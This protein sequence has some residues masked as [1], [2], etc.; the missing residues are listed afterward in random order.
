[1]FFE[2]GAHLASI[3]QDKLIW[4]K[5]VQKQRGRIPLPPDARENLD[6]WTSDALETLVLLNELVDSLWL[7]PRQSAPVKLNEKM[8]NKSLIGLEIFSDR[9]VLAVYADGF[10]NLWDTEERWSCSMHTSIH[11]A[12]SYQAVLD[13]SEEK[14]MKLMIV[15]MT[16]Q[17]Y[18]L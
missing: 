8:R 12:L 15:I 3:T 2:T 17:S 7:V 5:L 9:W 6:E 18:V 11:N 4:A 13:N 16:A 10:V 1:M 14:L